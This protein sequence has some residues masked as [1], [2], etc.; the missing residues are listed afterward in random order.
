MSFCFRLELQKHAKSLGLSAIIIKDAGR[1]QIAPGSKTVLAIG[2]GKVI[3][4]FKRERERLDEDR[5]RLQYLY[6]QVQILL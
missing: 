1:T 5:Y 3:N 6:F 2:P 4:F